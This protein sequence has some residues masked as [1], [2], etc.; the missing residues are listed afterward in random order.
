LLAHF[1]SFVKCFI[2]SLANVKCRFGG[3]GFCKAL[4]YK[5]FGH[6]PSGFG[7]GRI[8]RVSGIQVQESHLKPWRACKQP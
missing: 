3:F 2:C 8:F 5:G 1:K 4:L 6:A 7:C